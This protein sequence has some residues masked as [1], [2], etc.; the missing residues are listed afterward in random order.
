MDVCSTDY[1]SI[2]VHLHGNARQHCSPLYFFSVKSLLNAQILE[3]KLW[4]Q[5]FIPN[6]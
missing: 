1:G 3:I 4:V 2:V 6:T 5:F